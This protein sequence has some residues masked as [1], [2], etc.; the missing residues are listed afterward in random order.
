MKIALDAMGGDFAPKAI[1][2]GAL[3]AR[4]SFP[5]DVEIILIGKESIIKSQ[6]A[7]LKESKDSFQIV[8]ADSVIEMNEHPAKAFTQKK[9]S[10]IAAGFGLLMQKHAAAFC[11]AGN[12]GAMLVGS[13]FTIKPIKGILRPAIAGYLPKEAGGY[14]VVID[15]GANADCKPEMLE[16]FGVIGS[17][18]S[19]YVFNI[20]SPKVG[21]MNLGEEEEKG[22]ILTQAAHQLLKANSKINFIGNIE[23]RDIFND[24]ADVIVCDGFTGNVMLKMAESFYDLMEH[25]NHKDSFIDLFN[26]ASVG[27]SPIL[28]VNGNVIIGHGVSSPL[29]IKNMLNQA[30]QLVDSDISEKIKCAYN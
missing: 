10:S 26:Y 5:A 30:A 3:L 12:T 6:L 13:M 29:A 11:S 28:G 23:G 27:G 1:I 24:K 19:Q 4:K 7:D 20:K 8:N 9:D 16:Q 14:G 21:L 2:E 15:V 25:R 17:L 18:Y 22:N